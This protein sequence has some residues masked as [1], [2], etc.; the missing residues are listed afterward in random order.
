M[1]TR[2]FTFLLPCLLLAACG[3]DG[4]GAAA[5]AS[6]TPSLPVA[7]ALLDNGDESTLLTVE[8]AETPEQHERGFSGRTSLAEDRGIVFVFFEERDEALATDG[9]AVPLSIAFFDAEGTILRIVDVEPCRYAG[10][11]PADPGVAYMAALAVNRGSF[12]EWEISEG[13]AVHL[14]R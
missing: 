7:T 14:T 12:D 6:P 2:F 11:A 3:D 4:T 5:R 13:D 10:C 8:V 1:K 9:L